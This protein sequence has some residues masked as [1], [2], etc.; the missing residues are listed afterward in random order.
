MKAIQRIA[1]ERLVN[2]NYT[3]EMDD[4]FIHHV[5]EEL[6]EEFY[7]NPGEVIKNK[8]LDNGHIFIDILRLV[9]YLEGRPNG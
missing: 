9:Y 7:N 4:Y 1:L 2:Y 8:R 3:D 5:P 6:Q